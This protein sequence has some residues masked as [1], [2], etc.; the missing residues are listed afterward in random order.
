MTQDVLRLVKHKNLRN[1]QLFAC[2]IEGKN[3]SKTAKFLGDKSAKE[4]ILSFQTCI[5]VFR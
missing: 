3:H 2:Y 5:T 1:F 4:P